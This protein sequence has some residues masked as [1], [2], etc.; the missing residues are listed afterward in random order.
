MCRGVGGKVVVDASNDLSRGPAFVKLS[1]LPYLAEKAPTALGFRAFNSV[2]WENMAD[3]LPA[4]PPSPK[5]SGEH[6]SNC[7]DAPPERA[8]AA[9]A[10]LRTDPLN[11][12]ALR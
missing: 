8:S 3:S 9:P 4:A 2:G 1:S 5:E 12:R 7:A 10:A 6:M 11:L